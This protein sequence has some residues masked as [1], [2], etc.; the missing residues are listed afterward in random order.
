MKTFGLMLLFVLLGA[1]IGYLV[2]KLQSTKKSKEVITSSFIESKLADCSDLTTCNL[3]YVDLVKYE[4]GTIPFI[5]K[6]S[7]SMIYQANIRAGVDLNKA[8]VRVSPTTVTIKLPETEIQSIDVDTDS[9]RFYDEHFALF[10]WND[11]EDI[12]AAIKAARED[13]EKNANLEKLKIQ[14]RRQAETVIYKLVKPVLDE[15][16]EL[17]VE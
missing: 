4:N 3:E 2:F 11:K 6:R 1:V 5:S 15:G 17:V 7:F 10:N 8:E 12:S 16:R 14:A 13:A 9:L